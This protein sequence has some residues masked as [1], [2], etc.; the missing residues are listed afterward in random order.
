MNVRWFAFGAASGAIAGYY[1]AVA[2]GLRPATAAI[3]A[4]AAGALECLIVLGLRIR[5]LS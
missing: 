1:V 2:S 4:L 5:A 3:I